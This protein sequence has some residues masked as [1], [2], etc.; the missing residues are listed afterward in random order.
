MRGGGVWRHRA[1]TRGFGAARVS[2]IKSV[3]NDNEY[4]YGRG[5]SVRLLNLIQRRGWLGRGLEPGSVRNVRRS[6]TEQ[7]SRARDTPL[8]LEHGRTV[9]GRGAVSRLLVSAARRGGPSS[10]DGALESALGRCVAW[11]VERRGAHRA[12]QMRGP[13]TGRGSSRHA[14]QMWGVGQGARGLR[15]TRVHAS[16]R[17]SN[18]PART[19]PRRYGGRVAP[20]HRRRWH[21]RQSAGMSDRRSERREGGGTEAQAARR[22]L[23]RSPR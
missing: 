18:M 6:T 10:A 13:C 20:P 15:S 12:R 17:W 19:A 16:K 3:A 8:S 7:T 9:Q 2:S 22:F 21:S 1:T 14:R 23:R 4:Q 5:R 11:S